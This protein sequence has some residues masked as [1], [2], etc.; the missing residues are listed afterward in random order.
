MRDAWNALPAVDQEVLS[1]HYW[2]ALELGDISRLLGISENAAGT[3][4]S[5]ARARF[6][7]NVESSERVGTHSRTTDMKRVG[8]E[9]RST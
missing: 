3:R 8:S 4:L 5:R 2:D 7:H 1:L 6:K 9:R